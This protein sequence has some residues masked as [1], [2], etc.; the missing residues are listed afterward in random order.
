MYF[1]VFGVKIYI[2]F[3]FCIM[4]LLYILLDTSCLAIYVLLAS[5]LHE[6]GHIFALLVIKRVPQEINFVLGGIEIKTKSNES[7]IFVSLS[8]IMVN[9]LLFLFYYKVSLV[10]SA[11]N[12]LLGVFNLL[13]LYGLDGA[14]VLL[15]IL[16]NKTKA[17][18]IICIITITFSLVLIFYTLFLNN[19]S[20][21]CS[22]IIISVY[23]LLFGILNYS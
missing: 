14:T 13:P 11:T 19:T 10:F 2:S 23:F 9:F 12:L 7:N 21:K 4:V 1:S 22:L 18:K 16:K 5:F 3:F 15:E 17:Q 6:I 20:V 8:G